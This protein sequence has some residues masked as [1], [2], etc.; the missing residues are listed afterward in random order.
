TFDLLRLDDLLWA[1]KKITKHS[2]NFIPTGKS[3]EAILACYGG[4]AV[5][6]AK[7][8]RVD[9]ILAFSA[10]RAPWAVLGYSAELAT[11]FNKKVDEFA[12]AVEQRRREWQEKGGK[13]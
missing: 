3:H 11:I 7:E 8:K 4:I 12:G 10:Q 1:Y 13:A 5:I 6:K 9:E 2:V